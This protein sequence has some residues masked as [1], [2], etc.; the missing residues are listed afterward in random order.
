M[1]F[2][3]RLMLVVCF[4]FR[5]LPRFP[6]PKM[7]RLGLLLQ[8]KHRILF[9]ITSFF[10]FFFPAVASFSTVF[11]SALI[12]LISATSCLHAWCY[13]L[14]T[15]LSFWGPGMVLFTIRHNGD[16]CF[17]LRQVGCGWSMHR[18]A[19]HVLLWA[20]CFSVKRR[21][22]C[23]TCLVCRDS[24]CCHSL[25]PCMLNL[26]EK[27]TAYCDAATRSKGTINSR[28]DRCMSESA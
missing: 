10:F 17:C 9:L 1:A 26:R 19:E 8:G 12:S 18:N 15:G 20:I 2:Y 24:F 5:E 22:S 7:H 11:S 13:M 25:A 3:S 28:S 27:G 16:G 23:S 14:W 21:L 4:W 6:H